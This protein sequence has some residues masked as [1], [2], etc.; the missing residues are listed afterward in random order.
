[1]SPTRPSVGSR[2]APTRKGARVQVR[3]DRTRD[4]IIEET[5][6]C[7][8]EEGFAAASASHIAD[9]AGVTWGV[10]QYHFGDRNGLLAAVVDH[11]YRQF[12]QA[13]EA[14]SAPE[15][16]DRD[17]VAAVVDAAWSAFA[18]PESRASLEILVA[19]RAGRGRAQAA[20]LESMA[21]DM[22]GLGA[23]LV[24]PRSGSRVD[25]AGQGEVLLGARRGLVHTQMLAPRP[26]DSRAEREVLVD[27][28]ASFI[29]GARRPAHRSER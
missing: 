6:R 14:V 10:I 8:I 20:E 3:G 26:V 11:G 13:I 23:V 4:A 7:V 17:R 18:S 24:G 25:G 29:G 16:P 1:M 9:R 15:G 28:L 2:V 19:T 27:L 21:Q 5:V 12:R 22:R